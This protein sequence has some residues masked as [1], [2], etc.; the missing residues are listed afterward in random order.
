MPEDEAATVQKFLRKR[1][2]VE[3]PLVIS[4]LSVLRF[5]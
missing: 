3:L 4:R 5:Q 2:S 1:K